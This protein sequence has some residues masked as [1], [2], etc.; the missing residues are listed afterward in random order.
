MSIK[1]IVIDVKPN[2]ADSLDVHV[3]AFEEPDDGFVVPEYIRGQLSVE[4]PNLVCLK[5][6]SKYICYDEPC[7]CNTYQAYKL[8]QEGTDN[9]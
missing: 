8:Q 3:N 5:R 9:E 2:P 7:R 4:C 6:G 1:R